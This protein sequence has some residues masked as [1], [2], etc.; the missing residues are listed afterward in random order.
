MKTINSAVELY[1][2]IGGTAANQAMVIGMGWEPNRKPRGEV[3]PA[4]SKLARMVETRSIGIRACGTAERGIRMHFAQKAQAAMA[5]K[6]AK[7]KAR[8]KK[9]A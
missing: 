6:K 8:L 4:G 9:A 5:E 1:K 3:R 7:A 2:F